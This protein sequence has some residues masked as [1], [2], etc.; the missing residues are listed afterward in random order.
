MPMAIS[1]QLHFDVTR[2]FD[3]LFDI[4]GT[5]TEGDRGFGPGTGE[6]ALP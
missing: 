2:L 3:Q 1:E 6:C 4:Q 5:V